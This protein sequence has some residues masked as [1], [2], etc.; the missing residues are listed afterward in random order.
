MPRLACPCGFVHNLSLIPDDGWLTIRDRDYETLRDAE[1]KH[2]AN[3]DDVTLER[4]AD[5]KWSRMVG[6]FYQCPKCGRIMWACAEEKTYR[7]YL[8]EDSNAA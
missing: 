2:L 3:T 1:S 5:M 4:D 7:V 8:P 6:R